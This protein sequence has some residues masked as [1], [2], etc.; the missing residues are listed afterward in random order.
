M[1]YSTKLSLALFI[2]MLLALGV[3]GALAEDLRGFDDEAIL[4]YRWQALARYY[5][6]HDMLNPNAA[7][8]LEAEECL[9]FRWAALADFYEQHDLLTR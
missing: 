5:E 2:V 6:M 4:A 8:F 3:G 7:F 9:C 1:R